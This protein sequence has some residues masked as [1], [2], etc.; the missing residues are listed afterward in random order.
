MDTNL[1]CVLLERKENID[2]Q[3][4]FETA[5]EAGHVCSMAGVARAKHKHGQPYSANMLLNSLIF[6]YKPTRWIYQEHALY[7]MEKKRLFALDIATELDP[8]FMGGSQCNTWLSYST[9]RFC[10]RVKHNAGCNYTNNG[11]HF[12]SSISSIMKFI[13]HNFGSIG[14]EFDKLIPICI[15]HITHAGSCMFYSSESHYMELYYAFKLP[16]A[17]VQR[18]SH[19]CGCLRL[20]CQKAAMPSLQLARNNSCSLQEIYEGWILYDTGYCEEEALSKAEMFIAI[21]RSFEALF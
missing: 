5:A 13:A 11:N 19:V 10:K 4:C 2:A 9:I 17:L 6:E 16:N 14:H 3:R 20:N 7:N 21:Q 8:T 18:I 15:V 1:G 12:Y